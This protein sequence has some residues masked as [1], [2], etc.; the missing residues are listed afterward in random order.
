LFDIGQRSAALFD[1]GQEIEHVP[2]RG[3]SGVQLD[4][5]LREVFGIFLLLVEAI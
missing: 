1:C 3:G 4:I 2:P 5:G